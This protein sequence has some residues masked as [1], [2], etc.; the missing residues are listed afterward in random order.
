MIKIIHQNNIA[1]EVFLN[2]EKL[3]Y[4]SNKLSELLFELANR[5][6]S[7]LIIW[8]HKKLENN[9]NTGA[10]NQIFHHHLIMASFSTSHNFVISDAIGYVEQSSP[11]IKIN[12][13]VKYPTWRM[14][15]DVG[16][17]NSQVLN[18]LNHSFL[19]DSNF[20]YFLNSLA[21]S[22]QA[23]GLLCYSIPK[24]LKDETIVIAKKR[25][26]TK[27][28]FKFVKQHY[29]N[30]WVLLLL[31]NFVMYEKKIVLFSFFNS[32][33]VKAIKINTDFNLIKINSTKK[34]EAFDV[35]VV[36]P[37]LGRANYLRDVLNDLSNQTILPK[38]V[39]IIEQNSDYNSKT[40]L[41]FINNKNWPFEID[42]KLIHQ[43]GACNARNLALKKVTANWVFFADDDI[44]IPNNFIKNA[45]ITIKKLGANVMTFSCLLK[46]EQEKY[47]NY[48]QWSTFGSGCS[49]VNLKELKQVKFNLAFE[50]GF[51][52]D[53]EFGMQLRNQGSD[54]L[55]IP[56]IKI[57]HLKAPIGGFR[58]RYVHPW[59]NDNIQP[60]PSPTVMLY[61][62]K[63]NS[64][65]QLLGY[66]T[67]L[68]LKFYSS[69]KN[70]NPYRYL[71]E[72]NKRW[73]Q[74]KKWSIILQN[75][76]NEI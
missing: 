19:K 58:T 70:K 26:Q 21:K 48:F 44:K 5:F 49:M 31:L 32:V 14:S 75:Q 33:F 7:V 24:L 72:M 34:T 68:F 71:S 51:G 4:E 50:H 76:A 63:H 37:T 59:E 39:I 69:Q 12:F 54:I 27:Q 3:E 9:L 11:F 20:E 65:K 64:K 13:K 6:P 29:K 17:I 8:C 1:L 36:I 45:T 67:L 60:K 38:K 57:L 2:D 66:K 47:T 15:S 22:M 52:E 42:H 43:L 18:L 25:S 56:N 10:Y 40:E 73:E 46:G 16:G 41:D 35:D 28:L 61:N 55:Y 53:A 62:L 30:R 23:K 74:S